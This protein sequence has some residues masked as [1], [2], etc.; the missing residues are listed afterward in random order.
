MADIAQAWCSVEDIVAQSGLF[1]TSATR[2]PTDVVELLARNRASELQGLLLRSDIQV[3]PDDG[4]AAVNVSTLRGQIFRARLREANA[5]GAAID[6]WHHAQRGVSPATNT[7]ISDLQRRWMEILPQLVEVG[8][9]FD[10]SGRS[11]VRLP[12]D[13]EIERPALRPTKGAGVQI[14][15]LGDDL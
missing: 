12:Y 11:T 2:P 7:R 15:V 8:I 6:Q 14:T 9:E 5:V 13:S 10:S 1:V 3:T 4:S